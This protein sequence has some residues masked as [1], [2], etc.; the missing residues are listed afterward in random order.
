GLPFSGPIGGTRVALIDDQWVAFP[1]YSELERA[2]FSMV[3][4]GRIVTDASGAQDVAVM[5]V[6]AEATDNAWT[7]I[8]DKGATVPTE[9]VVAQGLEAAK[10]FI[11]ALCAAQSELAA[12]TSK[13]TGDFPLFPDYQ[14]D[15]YE[16]VTGHVSA[17][18]G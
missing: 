5:M 14:A 3:V 18:L 4:A 8:K 16:A 17:D 7:L 10:P 12:T 11:H 9:E 2:V 15:A 13:P 1:R 6:E